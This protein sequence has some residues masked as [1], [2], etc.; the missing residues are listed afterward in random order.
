MMERIP[1]WLQE[2]QV[3]RGNSAVLVWAFKLGIPV[4]HSSADGMLTVKETNL[5]TPQG[6]FRAPETLE[7]CKIG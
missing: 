1:G 2:K 4:I 6:G 5:E 3:C 7:I